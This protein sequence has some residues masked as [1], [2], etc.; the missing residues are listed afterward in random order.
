MEAN[1]AK[2]ILVQLKRQIRQREVYEAL[3]VAIEALAW[4]EL[5]K[6]TEI[7]DGLLLDEK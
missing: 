5:D 2:D 3:D 6:T 4:K 7:E 1:K